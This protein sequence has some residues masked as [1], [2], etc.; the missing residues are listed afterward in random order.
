MAKWKVS[1]TG[2]LCEGSRVVEGSN[3][4]SL[5]EL[6]EI[7]RKL[8]AFDEILTALKGSMITK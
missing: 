4:V 7:A 6:E 8:N 1:G 3:R 2:F 5:T